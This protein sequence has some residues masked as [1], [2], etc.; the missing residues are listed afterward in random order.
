[1]NSISMKDANGNDVNLSWAGN[2]G[3]SYYFNMPNSDV[4]LTAEFGTKPWP[5]DEKQAA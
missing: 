4:T 2:Y 3:G 5:I 1:M